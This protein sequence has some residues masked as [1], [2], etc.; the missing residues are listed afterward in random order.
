MS[1][2]CKLNDRC[3]KILHGLLVL[4]PGRSVVRVF[5][6]TAMWLHGPIF[7]AGN[8]S[9]SGKTWA[10][11][12]RSIAL[13][14]I[15]LSVLGVGSQK[16]VAQPQV[17][18]QWVTLPYLM[19]I[20]PIRLDL[21][22]N[23]KL[24]IVAGSENDPN[25]HLQ[26]SS[27]AALWDLSAQTITVQQ[28]LWDVFC[29]GGTFFEDGRCMVVGGT[30]QYDPFY[31]NRRTTVFD[32]VTNQFNQLHSM[33]HGR[34]YATAITLGDGRVLAFSGLDETG[35][36]N[37]TVEIYKVA[38]DALGPA[39]WSPPYNAGWTPPLYPW[40]HLLPNGTIFYSG[41][42]PNSQIFNP[43]V[44]AANPTVAGAGWTNVATTYYDLNRTYGFSVLL[45]LL[46]SN[47]YAPRV[48]ILGGGDW[49]ATATRKSS[50]SPSL[51]LL[52]LLLVICPLEL[53]S[54][55]MRYSCQ[56]DGSWRSADRCNM[57]T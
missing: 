43:A 51:P 7:F 9:F 48:M 45:P 47:N 44:A 3:R 53:A 4:V 34:W 18:G 31:G 32:P 16:V 12:R 13:S 2:F 35:A 15:S 23:G 10:G 36:T 1:V 8:R 20:N 46:P 17:T 22:R 55:E 49:T 33:A 56:M 37:Q 39:G 5:A 21:L 28:M 54:K 42:S 40:L 50:T 25:K 14:T 27:K 57:K 24:L 30:V 19:P 29:N 6:E 26:G 41:S 52:G 11:F 38:T